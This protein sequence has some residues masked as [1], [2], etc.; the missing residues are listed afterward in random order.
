[1]GA[2][3]RILKDR[4]IST[5][6]TIR[7]VLVRNAP[8]KIKQPFGCYFDGLNLCLPN[9]IMVYFMSLGL[10]NADSVAVNLSLC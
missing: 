4:P 5:G 2:Q 6:P 10:K 7:P 8:L 9:S 3:V 1:M